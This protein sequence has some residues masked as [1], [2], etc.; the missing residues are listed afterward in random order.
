M[1]DTTER[2]EAFEAG[3]IKL[4]GTNYD[5]IISEV[6]RLLNDKEYYDFM[7]K[8]NNPYGDGNACERII[9]FFMKKKRTRKN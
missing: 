6:S 7:A 8:A 3:T 5:L 2:S 1:R 9:K 4:V